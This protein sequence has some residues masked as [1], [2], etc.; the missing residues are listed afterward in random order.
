MISLWSVFSAVVWFSLASL[1]LYAL[2]D[3]TELL[4][5]YGVSAWS[6]AVVLTIARLLL[7]FDSAHM[8]VLR[9][10]T[11]LPALQNALKYELFHHLSVRQLLLGLWIA[12]ACLGLLRIVWGLLC[13][14]RQRRSFPSVTPPPQTQSVMRACNV[15]EGMVCVT[16]VVHTPVV[17]GFFHPTIYLPSIEYDDADLAWILK[18]ELCHVAGLDAW[19][20]LGFLLFRCLFWWNPA[21]HWAQR[22]VNDVLELRCDGAVLKGADAEARLEYSAALCHVQR[23]SIGQKD[24]AF[25]G[26]GAF[27]PYRQKELLALRVRMAVENPKP[28]NPFAVLTSI[29]AV[30][31][32]AASY[33]FILQPAGFPPDFAD[34]VEVFMVSPEDSYLKQTSSGS[35]ELWCNGEF[36]GFVHPD[37]LD[38]ELYQDLEI[39]P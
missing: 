30:G 35:Y 10:Y 15:P 36:A 18:H 11:V 26:M 2:R 21:V 22:S 33:M 39:F 7:P 23:L 12:G 28:W 38:D 32:F 9:S 29:L 20:K 5:H 19:L 17:V 8:I 24:P 31:L 14:Y 25:L 1:L 13:N 6:I 4:V 34:G 16:P 37:T 27:S 3:H